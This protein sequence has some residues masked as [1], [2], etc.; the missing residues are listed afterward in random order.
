MGLIPTTNLTDL[1]IPY[2]VGT[3]YP[4]CFEEYPALTEIRGYSGSAAEEYAKEYD[5]KFVSLGEMPKPEK[6]DI[7]GNGSLNVS[8][9]VLLQRWLIEGSG[10]IRQWEQADFNSDDRRTRPY[11]DEASIAQP[12]YPKLICIQKALRLMGLQRFLCAK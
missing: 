10:N 5:L 2:S 12:E 6:G 3:I 11:P 9:L 7:N 8:D 1:T 4:Y